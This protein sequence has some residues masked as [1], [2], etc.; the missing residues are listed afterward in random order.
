MN[1]VIH[2]YSIPLTESCTISLPS[3]AQI[4]HVDQ[5][6]GLLVMWTLVDLLQPT[7]TRHFRVLGTGIPIARYEVPLLQHISTVLMPDMFVWH[8]FEVVQ[9]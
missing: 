7:E 1:Y 3:K 5:Q 4:L 8:V 2:K 9:P 6:D